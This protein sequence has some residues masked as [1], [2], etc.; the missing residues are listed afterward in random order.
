MYRQIPD[1]GLIL[2][3]I[4]DILLTTEVPNFEEI[5]NRNRR[6]PLDEESN[7]LDVIRVY[8]M[9]FFAYH[10]VNESERELG[11]RFE[12]DAEVFLNTRRAGKTDS[13]R[14]TVNYVEIYRIVEEIILENEYR[15]IEAIAEDIA[16]AVL[17]RL[18][19]EAVQVRVRKP[20]V[21]IPGIT[22]GVEV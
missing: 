2:W 1:F 13:L 10:G 17:E 21:P 14:D 22:V 7:N 6:P 20:H 15:L 19:V 5:S 11:Q 12:V 9:I 8:G 18:P 16:Q 4:F 3:G